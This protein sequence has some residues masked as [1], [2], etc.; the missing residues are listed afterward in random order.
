MQKTIPNQFGRL[1]SVF[2]QKFGKDVIGIVSGFD[3]L[4]LRGT[5]RAFYQPRM[6]MEHLFRLQVLLKDFKAY[7]GPLTKRLSNLAKATADRARRPYRYLNSAQISKEELAREI[8][9]RDGIT[10][11]LIAVMAC[12]EP[13]RT[14][15]VCSNRETK[16]LEL[17]LEPS[18]CQY[19]YF[20][21]IHRLFGLMHLRLQSWFPFELNICLN[22]REW[23]ARQM[24][25]AGIAYLRRE[26]TFT[27]IEDVPRAQ[28][29]ME[30]QLQSDW[31]QLLDALVK[32]SH[33]LAEEI[34]RPLGM[35][36][37]WSACES[38][39]ATDIMFRDRAS[40]AL[41]YPLLVA[42]GMRT[43][44][45]SEVM[46]FLGRRVPASG[47][48]PA[49][50]KGEV[51]SD[52]RERAEGIRLKHRVNG[53]SLKIYDKQ[54][55]VLRV[56]T[57]INK[58]EEF[59]VWRAAE[60]DVQGKMSWRPL[61]WGIAD[62]HRR[63]EVS[64]AANV[65]YIQAL[66]AV[67]GKNPIGP[68][69]EEISRP[70]VRKTKRYRALN[71]WSAQDL[72]LLQAVMRGEF[73]INGLRNRDLRRLFYQGQVCAK[74]QRRQAASITRKLALLRAHRLLRK[75]TGTHRYVVTEK[76]RRVITALLT[77]RDADLDQ[78]NKLAA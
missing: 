67:S 75:I 30:R 63:A 3:R 48:V 13:C 11:G 4:R 55:S 57:T 23:L 38:E 29:L 2:I 52:L 26:N 25:S 62:L 74:E 73:A 60:G 33:P 9:L 10:R 51:I 56:E 76:A 12:V 69:I 64:H 31:P 70:V 28:A 66:G 35:S 1:S 77:L 42:H 40:L 7:A 39:Y 5:L 50:F 24:D 46:R 6:M 61:R 8:A 19:F 65:R 14:Y 18:R 44:A 71:P 72:A 32:R 78:L 43:F 54:G 21:Y 20:Y 17:R 41:H 37:Y 16:R 45:S 15:E 53:N 68:W 58:P 36:Y 59:R 49:R 27:W 47:K 34:T 22:G